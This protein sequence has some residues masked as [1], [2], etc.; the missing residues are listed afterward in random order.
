MVPSTRS[1]TGDLPESSSSRP[2][3]GHQD[4]SQQSRTKAYPSVDSPKRQKDPSA[5]PIY[6]IDLSLPPEKRYVEL[7]SDFTAQIQ[8]LTGL[9][10]EVVHDLGPRIP[11]RPVCALARVLLRGLHSREETDELRGI[12]KTAGV[13]LYLLFCFNTL[14]DL[15]MGCTS[16]GVRVQNEDD[17][18][19]MLHFR[20]LDWG[21]DS[22]RK[23]IVQL[24]FVRKPGDEVF[25]SSITYAGYT[26]I[27]TG[28]SHLRALILSEEEDAEAIHNEK[29]RTK[30]T[31]R[32]LSRLEDIV[33]QFSSK[34]TTAAYIIVSDGE[35][36]SVIEKDRVTAEVR[37][38]SSFVVATNHDEASEE[39]RDDYQSNFTQG[40]ETARNLDSMHL[41]QDYILDESM[42]RKDCMVRRWKRVCQSS[43]RRDPEAKEEDVAI[44]E[45]QLVKWTTTWPTANEC[46]HYA[47]ILDPAK[48]E[49]FWSRRWMRPMKPPGCL[50]VSDRTTE[51]Q[52]G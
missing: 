41:S 43:R 5:I 1:K 50:L 7:A 27:L 42:D 18:S 20:T 29:T 24:N 46:T 28:V 32:S 45:K 25:A 10:D 21:M 16:G 4:H 8:D 6:T 31:P 36:T 19:H 17:G 22:L 48:G 9:F 13:E 38:S 12:S 51:G 30:Q 47:A 49:I 23:V 39:N 52:G 44:T 37:T 40:F 35:T 15:F 14:L 3:D 26:G 11:I 33:L 2:V 34:T